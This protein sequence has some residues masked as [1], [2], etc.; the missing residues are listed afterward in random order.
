MTRMYILT[1][2]IYA[3]DAYLFT[4]KR[5]SFKMFAKIFAYFMKLAEN[6]S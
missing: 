6:K 3:K 5:R 2:L 1:G 4:V